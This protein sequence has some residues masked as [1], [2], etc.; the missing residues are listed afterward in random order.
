[1]ALGTSPITRALKVLARVAREEAP[2]SLAELS[3]AV[4]LPKPTVYRIAALLEQEGVVYKDPLTRRYSMGKAF[5]DLCFQAIRNGPV[6]RERHFILQRLSEKL[7]ETINLAV[8]V[9]REVTYIERVEAAW[10]LSIN[11]EPGS[12]VPVHCTANGKLLLA[13]APRRHRERFLK[14]IQ[15]KPYTP[16]TIVDR[17]RLVQRLQEIRRRGYSE[18]NEEFLAGVCC[19]AVPV[20]D[21]H[22]KVVAGLAVSAPSARFSLEKARSYLPDLRACTAELSAHLADRGGLGP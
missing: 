14:S 17:A 9:G 6:H 12:R 19:L 4:R 1:M 18:D 16:N 11:F 7:G 5:H 22:G 15:L 2:L 20:K 13:F 10:P 21:R 8:L 3:A